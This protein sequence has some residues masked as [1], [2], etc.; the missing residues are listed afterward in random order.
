MQK[1]TFIET[2]IK[3]LKNINA[4]YQSLKDEK[5]FDEIANYLDAGKVI[6]WFNGRM[7][8]G[9]RALGVR[10][11]IG[12]PRNKN[13][14]KILNLKIKYRESFLRF[15]PSV[16]EEDVGNLF[17][18]KTKSPYMLFVAPVKKEPCIKM[19]RDQENLFG[20]EKLNL[21]RS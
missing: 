21:P 1:F 4:P 7:E 20:F 11:I 2:I 19:K 14:Q 3:L 10:S 17:E 12:D 6:G 9:P 8:F 18:F 5:L 16:L 15:A 13:M